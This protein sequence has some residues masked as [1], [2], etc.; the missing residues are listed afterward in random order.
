MRKSLKNIAIVLAVL[1][2]VGCNKTFHPRKDRMSNSSFTNIIKPGHFNLNLYKISY[3]SGYS[4]KKQFYRDYQNFLKKKL[5]NSNN[6]DVIVPKE[7]YRDMNLLDKTYLMSEENVYVKPASNLVGGEIGTISRIGAGTPSEVSAVQRLLNKQVYFWYQALGR[8]NEYNPSTVY[9][10]LNKEEL[11]TQIVDERKE[12]FKILKMAVFNPYVEFRSATD[13]LEYNGKAVGYDEFPRGVYVRNLPS[14]TVQKIFT[15][16]KKLASKIAVVENAIYN[17]YKVFDGNRV[18]YFRGGAKP[19]LYYDEYTINLN[20]RPVTLR[21][22]G[23]VNERTL[24]GDF[25]TPANFK[26]R[27]KKEMEE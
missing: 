24:L 21:Q 10:E 2:L 3:P 1:S 19:V 6:L 13:K 8:G 12:S 22:L 25:L 7:F 11:I 5:V 26:S 15:G 18:V 27:R 23:N 4:A 14:S 20:I 9:S 17:G 16:E